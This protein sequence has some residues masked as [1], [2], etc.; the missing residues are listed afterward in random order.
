MTSDLWLSFLEGKIHITWKKLDSKT[1]LLI[2]SYDDI[3]YWLRLCILVIWNSVN[4]LLIKISISATRGKNII[5]CVQ[6]F[7]GHVQFIFRL[8]HSSS[9][10][11]NMFVSRTQSTCNLQYPEC[12][13]KLITSV[14]DSYQT[15]IMYSIFIV[16]DYL[17]YRYTQRR[18]QEQ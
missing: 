2:F 10:Y 14:S 12:P 1:D 18:E 16:T 5:N 3:F 6:H 4:Y 13:N 11:K 17:D 9:S 15:V 7:P 8:C